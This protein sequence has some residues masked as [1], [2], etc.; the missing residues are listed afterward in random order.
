MIKEINGESYLYLICQKV[1]QPIGIFYVTSIPWYI[2]RKIAYVNPRIL[3]G[4]DEKGTEIY[5]GI[6]RELSKDR[7]A[8]IKRY[9]E[10]NASTFP[11]S[12]IINIPK[13]E[14][15]IETLKINIIEHFGEQ[16]LNDNKELSLLDNS[17]LRLEDELFLLIVRYREGVAQIVD[18]QHR[19]S[20]FENLEEKSLTFDLPITIF[21]DQLPYAQA[22]IFATI[23]GK[24]TRVTPSLVFDLFGISQKRNPYTVA[25]YIVKSLNE[26]DT[27]PL[28]ESIKILGKSNEYYNGFVTQSTVSKII[29]DLI[30]GNIKQ[31]EEDSRRMSRDMEISELPEL[32]NRQAP[33]R[34]YFKAEKDE[35]ILK[36]L[37]NFFN[38]VKESF[39]IEWAKENSVL[40]KT[41][42]FTALLKILPKLIEIGKE[43]SDWSQSFFKTKFDASKNIDFSQIQLSSKG[44]NQLVERFN[45]GDL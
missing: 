7:K 44:V 28:K 29:I 26:S 43:Q 32:T 39:P 12:I 22:E 38:A 24:Q 23:N 34:K 21:F 5:D 18:G 4:K 11:S 16:D 20:G 36:V 17:E 25:R 41:V 3:L 2:L 15:R 27:S 14:L 6:Q 9:L 31:A 8:E 45:I 13:D 19:M 1:E 40:K 10:G 30:C 37:L 35:V 42:G 33:L